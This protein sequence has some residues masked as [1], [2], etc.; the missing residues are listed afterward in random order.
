[1][2]EP[3]TGLLT[4]SMLQSA[5]YT[6]L[7]GCLDG[8]PHAVPLPQE[9]KRLRKEDRQQGVITALSSDNLIVLRSCPHN[10]TG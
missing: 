1:M 8:H 7:E 2:K 5:C 4:A 6:G 10:L 3:L 9:K